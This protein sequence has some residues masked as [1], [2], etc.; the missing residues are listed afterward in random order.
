MWKGWPANAQTTAA[1]SR[2][3]PSMPNRSETFIQRG[4]YFPPWDTPKNKS[5]ASSGPRHPR[6]TT[7]RGARHALALVQKDA[8]NVVGRDAA[9][10]SPG[11]LTN[12]GFETGSIVPGNFTQLGKSFGVVLSLAPNDNPQARP[13]GTTGGR[14]HPRLSTNWHRPLLGTTKAIVEQTLQTQG[15]M[16]YRLSWSMMGLGGRKVS[17]STRDDSS[18]FATRKRLTAGGNV[19]GSWAPECQRMSWHGES[20]AATVGGTITQ[21]CLSGLWP[22]CSPLQPPHPR[23]M[24]PLGGITMILP[25]RVSV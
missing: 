15:G 5:H 9:P 23:N 14:W 18:A 22:T 11:I 25:S 16:G 2:N 8:Q 4:H 19:A 3:S 17:V 13:D 20:Q 6:Y 1:A 12:G 7:A 24:V 10:E 21:P